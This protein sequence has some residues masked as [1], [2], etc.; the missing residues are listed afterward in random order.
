V[1]KTIFS[2]FLSLILFGCKQKTVTSL[3]YFNTADFTPIW[4]AKNSPQITKL[5]TISPF[6]FTDQNG[7]TVTE[8]T[9]KGKIYVANFFFTRCQNICPKMMD[10]LKKVAEVISADTNVLIIS[11]S[12]TPYFDNV[13]VLKK[14]A[15]E[16]AITTNNWHLVTGN[17]EAIYKIARKSYFADTVTSSAITSQFL[18]TE[19]FILVDKNRHIRGVYNGTIELEVENLIRH[20]KLLEQEN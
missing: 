20:I 8:R 2:F 15:K 6:L 3:P 4:I 1:S 10:N 7:K 9:I 12:V 17:K 13:A 11:H 18:H 14:Y 16:K 5:H 19:N